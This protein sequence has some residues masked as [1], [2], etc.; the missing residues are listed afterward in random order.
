MSSSDEFVNLRVNRGF[1]RRFVWTIVVL[2]L[3]LVIAGIALSYTVTRSGSS[4]LESGTSS[5]EQG[6]PAQ[7]P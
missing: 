7:T 5:T 2:I 3:V 4:E 6:Y 1:F